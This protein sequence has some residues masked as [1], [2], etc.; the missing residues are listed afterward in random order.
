[1]RSRTEAH[2]SSRI[3]TSTRHTSKQAQCDCLILAPKVNKNT[4]IKGLIEFYLFQAKYCAIVVCLI[5]FCMLSYIFIFSRRNVSIFSA[6]N[7]SRRL[8]ISSAKSTLFFGGITAVVS[9]EFSSLVSW[10]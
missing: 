1:M 8:I 5:L 6:S 10:F 2:Q 9:A 7:C 4:Q 3:E